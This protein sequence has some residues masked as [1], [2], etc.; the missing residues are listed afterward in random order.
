MSLEE[1]LQSV[2]GSE[3]FDLTAS[4]GSIRGVMQAVVAPGVD[5]DLDAIG[6][7][8]DLAG[9]ADLSGVES[10]VRS[11]SEDGLGQLARLPAVGDVLQPLTTSLEVVEQ[12]TSA[13]FLQ[14]MQG[15]RDAGA[16]E[17]EPGLSGISE[18][19]S[20]VLG[21]SDRP[22]VTALVQ[23]VS[24]VAPGELS[25][26]G[27]VAD[28]RD[29]LAAFTTLTRLVGALMVPAGRSD[30]LVRSTGIIA[31]F[32]DSDEL[33]MEQ[34]RIDGWI[35][36]AT[37]ARRIAHA[38]PLNAAE[39][40]EITMAVRELMDSLQRLGDLT[41]RGL[42]FGEATLV[43]ADL[44]GTVRQIQDAGDLLLQL[45]VDPVRSAAEALRQRADPLLQ[46]E[47]AEPSDNLEAFWDR[48]TAL[49]APLT[50]IIDSLD[51]T[52]LTAPLTDTL[53]AAGDA[54]QQI[55]QVVQEVLV[56]IRG[57]M[58]SVRRLVKGLGLERITAAVRNFLQP[59]VS[60]VGQIEEVLSTALE[61]IEQAAQEA[62]NALETLQSTVES[63]AGAIEGAFGR[64]LDLV[65][66]LNLDQIVAR[67]R[68]GLQTVVDAL[69]R[70]QLQP[71]FD[72]ATDVMDSAA[73]VVEAV[74][75]ELL[76]DST[77]QELQQAVQPIKAIDFQGDVSD[78]LKAELQEILDHL[79]SDILGEVQEAF[80]R[81]IQFLEGV[82]P[83]GGIAALEREHYDPLVERV[84]SVD[85]EQV[86]QPFSDALET[87]QA[88]LA[89]LDPDALL[90]PV[91]E[92]FDQLLEGY[93]RLNPG[94]LVA[95][96]EGRL[97][98]LRERLEEAI[99]LEDWDDR[100]DEL[101]GVVQRL[102]ERLDLGEL[103]ELLEGVYDQLLAELASDPEGAG[104]AGG[105]WLTTLL[106]G[107]DATVDSGAF[108]RV[109]R[110]IG[111]EDGAAQT[112]GGLATAVDNLERT[113]T[114]VRA[115]DPGAMAARAQPLYSSLN[116][117]VA[118]LPEGSPLR[119]SL[120]PLLADRAPMELLAG[121][122]DGHG[123]YVT[124]LEEAL[125]PVRTLAGSGLSQLGTAS[126]GLR[127]ALRPLQPLRERL[128]AI[129]NRF[130]VETAGADLRAILVQVLRTLRPEVVLEP[131]RPLLEALRVKLGEALTEGVV[132][133]LK[134]AIEQVQQL[135]AA[136]DIGIIRQELET[137]HG[138][139]RLELESFRPRQ[140]LSELLQA[141]QQARDQLM[142][143]DPLAPIRTTLDEAK[144]AATR[145][146][147]AVRPSQLLAAPLATYELILELAGDLDVA[148][149]LEPVLTE[150]R[151]IEGQLG[152]GL[153]HTAGALTRLQ[154]ALP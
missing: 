152:E 115:L 135:I 46:L 7:A 1:T 133:P 122:V 69:D 11:V 65:Q 63:T 107:G 56:A 113:L 74:P 153:D 136:F 127:D 58:E 145:S 21:S 50:E 134:L 47:L 8:G 6:S 32:L 131:L 108:A 35:S 44:P 85:I 53:R 36:A 154:E 29:H 43:H 118:A 33:A 37:L 13:D 31:G 17:R 24:R 66:G 92:V 120:E 129:L 61:A 96:L 9:T 40:A 41:V 105:A 12:V 121:T 25:L 128:L 52:R 94:T 91:E 126:A 103:G 80:Q 143:F 102:L 14:I 15:L 124:A 140:A 5:L 20:A 111:G 16:G 138:E 84:R 22:Q 70:V 64:V 132:A 28:V 139:I 119:Q 146:L 67:I 83:R 82:D 116:S 93:D 99:G 130:G 57:A 86:L 123:R 26:P 45:G 10:A 27:A 42:A 18:A 125:E 88:N 89:R 76:P 90:E 112:R 151:D 55:N 141:L 38:D 117:A 81:V 142:A 77:E 144:A 78:V 49:L 54:L 137:L 101:N 100:V 2:F 59:V 3:G 104:G 97:D 75:V 68:E 30:E 23:L 34:N 51:A 60:A 79:D 95:D 4:L 114:A 109:C 62:R 110:W 19:V 148:N 72:R 73:R 149:L 147:E 87:L 98:G 39:T 150:L 48:A 106:S 71:Y